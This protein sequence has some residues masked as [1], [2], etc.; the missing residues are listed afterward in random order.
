MGMPTQIRIWSHPRSTH[1]HAH[2][3]M[4]V[5]CGAA[6]QE[7]SDTRTYRQRRVHARTH[8]GTHT[9]VRRHFRGRERTPG[10]CSGSKGFFS[11]ATI[12]APS[13]PSKDPSTAADFPA[14]DASSTRSSLKP[15]SERRAPARGGVRAHHNE[16]ALERHPPAV[17]PTCVVPRLRGAFA[18]PLHGLGAFE[19]WSGVRIGR[20]RG[21]AVTSN[22]TTHRETKWRRFAA[23]SY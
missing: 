7:P 9:Q 3:C 15:S 21:P 12:A 10:S 6:C 14:A 11:T 22:F 18:R 1:T 8:V 13:L 17:A 16:G 2:P 19:K 4:G 5:A 23:P 20:T